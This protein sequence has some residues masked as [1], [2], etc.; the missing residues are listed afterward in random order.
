MIVLLGTVAF[1]TFVDILEPLSIPAPQ[2][3]AIR[4]LRSAGQALHPVST[5]LNRFTSPS[6]DMG[7][8]NSLPCGGVCHFLSTLLNPFKSPSLDMGVLIGSPDEGELA[9]SA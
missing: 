1:A 6:L 8:V 7:G 4:L 2:H 3:G 5:V 9:R